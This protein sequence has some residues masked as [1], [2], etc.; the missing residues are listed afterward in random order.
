MDTPLIRASRILLGGS[1][2]AIAVVL[3]YVYMYSAKAGND[4]IELP[5][6]ILFCFFGLPWNLHIFLVLLFVTA[7]TGIFLS[8]YVPLPFI[9]KL[10]KVGWLASET[11]VSLVFG[12]FMNGCVLAWLATSK[13]KESGPRHYDE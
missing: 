8:H 10:I 2:A 1:A 12:A 7:K 5:F 6:F 9:E 4:S 3:F 13:P 11:Y